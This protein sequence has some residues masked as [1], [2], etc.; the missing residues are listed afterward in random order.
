[1]AYTKG[2]YAAF[3]CTGKSKF[4]IADSY[5]EKNK[6]VKIIWFYVPIFAFPHKTTNH[7]YDYLTLNKRD[8]AGMMGMR[9]KVL[10]EHGKQ[11]KIKGQF[12]KSE[13]EYEYI[14]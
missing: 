14:Y 8:G 5:A 10:D 12:E 9:Y 4:F 11:F 7:P 2:F 13:Y 3:G 6:G 1:M